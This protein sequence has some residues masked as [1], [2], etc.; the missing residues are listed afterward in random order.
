MHKDKSGWHIRR[1]T[2]STK[3]VGKTVMTGSILVIAQNPTYD[4]AVGLP[5]AVTRQQKLDSYISIPLPPL[6]II[7]F[8]QTYQNINNREYKIIYLYLSLVYLSTLTII[9]DLSTSEHQ[10]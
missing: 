1:S 5:T 3:T 4:E 6:V 10:L 2:R 8:K 7:M 9:N